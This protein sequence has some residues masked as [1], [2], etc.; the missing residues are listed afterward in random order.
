MSSSEQS[1]DNP[2]AKSGADNS[3]STPAPAKSEDQSVTKK[4]PIKP[5][6]IITVVFIIILLAVAAGGYYYWQKFETYLQKIQHDA[7]IID[8]KFSTV[9][10]QLDQAQKD[11]FLRKEEFT[12][13]TALLNKQNEQLKA[14]DESQKALISSTKNIFDITH[15]NQTQWLL[16]EVSYLLSL[17][18]QRLI[19]SRDI[20]T[21]VAALKAANNRLHD[22]SDP[23]LLTL[24]KTITNET[25]QLNL[26]KLPDIS[27]IAFS[28][29][30]M[31]LLI[32]DLPFK[33][34]QQKYIESKATPEKVEIAS[35]DKD[36]I[37]AP[38]WDR[39]KSLVT[40]RKHQRDIQ[41]TETPL[42][43]SDIDSQ[44]RYRLETSRVS[45]INK[46][47]TV[48]QHEVTSAL[49]LVTL[50]Y[51]QNDNRVTSLATELKSLSKI[52]LL[53][54]LPDIT[55]S[56]LKLQKFIALTNAGDVLKKNKGISIK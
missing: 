24:R 5:A 2:V 56:W 26:L 36:T 21:A 52:N 54:T 19:V 48:F 41:E 3:D 37:I 22:L 27:G 55:G 50:Y 10:P 53:P 42:Q 15:R 4:S 29:D 28:I 20:K 40:I 46:N 38:L 7:Q 8:R 1:T 12:Q 17:A 51:D 13:L 47:T 6:S 18:N 9:I 11:I 32:K 25:A 49:K 14:F 16:S 30:N 43:K 44:L 33:S 34:A 31:T 35:L 45:L 23:S 39:L